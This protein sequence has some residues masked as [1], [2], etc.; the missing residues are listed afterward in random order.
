MIFAMQPTRKKRVLIINANIA[1]TKAAAISCN[2]VTTTRNLVQSR[3]AAWLHGCMRLYSHAKGGF[4]TIREYAKSRGISYEAAAKQV[5]KYKSK[6]LKGHLTK[7]GSQT[8]LDDTAIEILDRHR[9]PRAV[10]MLPSDEDTSNEIKALQDENNNLKNQIIEMQKLLI[11]SKDECLKLSQ[12]NTAMIE[13]KARADALQK[14]LEES[15]QELDR[16]KPT[17]FGLYKKM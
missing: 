12:A 5:R 4:M 7:Q 1:I 6:D 14:Q 3:V 9:Q 2:V 17:L 10:V 16:Y 13:D 11:A 8:I 15:K